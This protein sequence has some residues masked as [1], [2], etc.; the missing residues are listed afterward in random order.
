MKYEMILL[1]ILLVVCF[2]GCGGKV[3]KSSNADMA[4]EA[5]CDSLLA[6]KLSLDSDYTCA[7]AFVME[8]STGKL[9][10]NVQVSSADSISVYGVDCL[11]DSTIVWQYGLIHPVVVAAVLQEDEMTLV[12]SIDVGNGVYQTTD[13][14]TLMDS[15][16][17]RGGWGMITLRDALLCGSAIAVRKAYERSFTSYSFCVRLKR[18]LCEQPSHPLHLLAFYN[19]IARQ[20]SWVCP[21]FEG[22]HRNE[23]GKRIMSE[24]VAGQ[25]AG[26]MKEYAELKPVQQ[27][28]DGKGWIVGMSGSCR[29]PD[30]EYLST[31][32]GFFPM[33]QP[34]YTVM[35][36]V[37]KWNLPV[38]GVAMAAPLM[39]RIADYL[40]G[41]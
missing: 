14:M 33:N 21:L 3:Q 30:G 34:R 6:W 1:Y 2:M 16:Y 38:S 17:R 15:N 9:K 4:L 20:G 13:G 23:Q 40:L 7:Q 36:C 24:E 25:L 31:Y 26:V 41:V 22:E 28:M 8:V 18:L 11:L 10:A 19:A 29:L 37:Q 39:S 5:Y 27:L 35:V 12:D 32:C